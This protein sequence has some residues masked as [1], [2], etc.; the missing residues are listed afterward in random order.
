MIRHLF[1]CPRPDVHQV[2]GNKGDL[3]ERCRGC[4]RWALVEVE[5]PPEPEPY[6]APARY[7]ASCVDC[8]AEVPAIR[9]KPRVFRCERCTRKPGAA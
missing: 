5:A 9:S 8:G 4:S 2:V 1:E 6:T 3:L 7:F